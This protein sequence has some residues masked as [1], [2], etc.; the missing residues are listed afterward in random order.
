VLGYLA[1]AALSPA[2]YTVGMWSDVQVN[3]IRTEL[4]TGATMVKLA[5]TERA[6]PDTEAARQ[7]IANAH[8]ALKAAKR[9]LPTLKN[10][11]VEILDELRRGIEELESA[12]SRYE[13]RQRNSRPRAD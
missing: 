9:F 11:H 13:N 8:T 1:F 12:I 6:M 4:Q 2:S 3:F 10:L 5:H 7:A